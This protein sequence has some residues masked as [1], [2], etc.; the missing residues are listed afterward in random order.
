[1]GRTVAMKH[2]FIL[3][4]LT[5]A[6]SCKT[7]GALLD[8]PGAAVAD[9]GGAVDAVTPDGAEQAGAVAET[10]ATILTGNPVVGGAV[11]VLVTAAAAFFIRRKKKPAA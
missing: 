11:G 2:L 3:L 6:P 7:F 8:I 5:F 10:G 9:V 1:M 4:I